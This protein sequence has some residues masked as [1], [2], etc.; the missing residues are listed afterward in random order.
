LKPHVLYLRYED[1]L[2]DFDAE[3]DRIGAFIGIDDA[4]ALHGF[5][6]HAR[7][8]G[9]ISTPSYAQ[10]TQPPNKTA[11]GRWLRYEDA[12]KPLLPLLKGVMEHWGYDG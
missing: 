10:V 1:L 5:H 3:V 6:L 12:F 2:D 11:V 8:K 7:Q 9:F 4:A